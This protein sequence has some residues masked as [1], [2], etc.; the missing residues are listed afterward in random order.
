VKRLKW[1]RELSMISKS[2]DFAHVIRPLNYT[3]KK[4][5]WLATYHMNGLPAYRWSPI[6]VLIGPDT[7][8]TTLIETTVLP[9]CYANAM[10]GEMT[11]APWIQ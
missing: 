10:H 11:S 2:Y 7:D 4:A 1:R 6:P 5:W 3:F 8:L 9:L